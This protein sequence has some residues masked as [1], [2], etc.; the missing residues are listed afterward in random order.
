[1][2]HLK[3]LLPKASVKDIPTFYCH[4]TSQIKFTFKIRHL[5]VYLIKHNMKQLKNILKL[6]LS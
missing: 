6:I 1:M 3:Y 2:Q 5:M 4:L